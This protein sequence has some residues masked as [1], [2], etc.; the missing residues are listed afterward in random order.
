MVD[1]RAPRLL[2]VVVVVGGGRYHWPKGLFKDG[3]M[4]GSSA[5]ADAALLPFPGGGGVSG[6][7][8][9]PMGKL[10]VVFTLGGS[11]GCSR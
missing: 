4:V 6:V 7:V 8:C 11:D 2:V 9:A 5:A 1:G 10:A 3:W